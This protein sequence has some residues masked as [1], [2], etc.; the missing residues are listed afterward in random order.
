MNP[1][2][3]PKDIA[4]S[5]IEAITT[6]GEHLVLQS[7]KHPIGI[8]LMCLQAT[9]GLGAAAAL[10]FFLV[11]GMVAEES[12][13]QALALLSVGFLLVAVL[14]IVILMIATYIYEQNRLIISNK[15]VTQI[16]QRALFDRK[17][18]ELSLGSIEDVTSTKAGILPSIFDYGELR[19]E[20]AGEQ[21]NFYFTYCPHPDK[22][23]QQLLDARQ[24]YHDTHGDFAAG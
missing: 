23:G 7:K 22:V 18:S 11:P 6:P 14:L 9:I 1:D 19:I 5:G 12:R 16:A 15:N 10:T 20:T 13:D 8:V 24:R 2:Q 21:N 3:Q 4:T 17:V